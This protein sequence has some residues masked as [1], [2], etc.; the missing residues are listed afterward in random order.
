MEVKK[1]NPPVGLV[2]PKISSPQEELFSLCNEYNALEFCL[3]TIVVRKRMT[4]IKER[5]DYLIKEFNLQMP[6]VLNKYDI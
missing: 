1:Y 3:D 5:I 4:E 6:V 2:F